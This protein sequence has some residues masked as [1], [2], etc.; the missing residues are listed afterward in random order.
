M[1]N[2]AY[3]QIKAS[4]RLPSPTG[5]ALRLLELA[6]NEDTTIDAIASVVESDPAIAGRVLK[7]VNSPLAGMT[8]QVGSVQR[9][10]ALLGLR[11]VTTLALSFSLVRKYSAGPCAAFDYNHYWSDSLARATAVRHLAQQLRG[12][13]PDEAFTCG[14]LSKVGRLAFA[15]VFPERYDSL[16]RIV[17]QGDPSELTELETSMFELDHNQ[18]TQLMLAD[19]HLPEV[20]RNAVIAQDAPEERTPINADR[21]MFLAHLL[22][23]GGLLSSVLTQSTVFREDLTSL[24]IKAKRIGIEPDIHQSVFDAVA[25]EWRE[26]SEVYQ[27]DA[28]RVPPLAEIYALARRRQEGLEVREAASPVAASL[29]E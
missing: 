19:W 21:S 14:L 23:Y 11:T 4:G 1:A 8:R 16:L 22:H 15:T 27:V 5:V 2:K 10:V 24:I 6:D 29:S 17:Q 28:R 12:F 18:I 3:E 7:L 13:A 20:F 9:A 25:E 26:A